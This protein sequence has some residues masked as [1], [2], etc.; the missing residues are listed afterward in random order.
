MRGL[1]K[2]RSGLRETTRLHGVRVLNGGHDMGQRRSSSL[3]ASR[4]GGLLLR[5]P[6]GSSKIDLHWNR[7]VR[8]KQ[9]TQQLSGGWFHLYRAGCIISTSSRN[10]ASA[11]SQRGLYGEAE[12]TRWILCFCHKGDLD[13]AL[14]SHVTPKRTGGR[15]LMDAIARLHEATNE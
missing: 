6:A 7:C 13:G 9:V 4:H 14:S 15:H 2:S 8:S 12:A 1:G 11:F 5:F 3:N 10:Y